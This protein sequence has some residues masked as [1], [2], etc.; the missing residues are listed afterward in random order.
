MQKPKACL[1]PEFAD[2]IAATGLTVHRQ[3]GCS[4]Y[5][6]DLGIVDPEHPGKYVLGVECDGAT[7][8]I[9]PNCARP[10]STS[11]ADT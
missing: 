3:I 10:G 5:R 2:A 1:S 4:G 11:A 6:I 8:R 7:Y 9:R